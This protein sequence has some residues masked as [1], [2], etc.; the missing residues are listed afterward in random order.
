MASNNLVDNCGN[1]QGIQMLISSGL[2]VFVDYVNDI[3]T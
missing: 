2:E 3:M 1:I